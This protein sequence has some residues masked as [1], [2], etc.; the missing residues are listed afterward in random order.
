VENVYKAYIFSH[1]LIYLP[2]VIQIDG[3]LTQF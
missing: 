3:H 1:F 2:K